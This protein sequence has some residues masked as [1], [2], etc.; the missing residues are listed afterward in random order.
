MKNLG[1]VAA[2]VAASAASPASAQTEPDKAVERVQQRIDRLDYIEPAGKMRSRSMVDEPLPPPWVL[3][4]GA[5]FAY[6]SNVAN[7]ETGRDQAFHF[8][9]SISLARDWSL[10]SNVTLSTEAGAELD[11]YTE[12]SENDLSDWYANARVTVGDS[13]ETISPYADYTTLALYEKRF[14]AHIVTLHGFTVGASRVWKSGDKGKWILD[15][16][17]SRREATIKTVELNRLSATGQY[18]FAP[19]DQSQWIFALA[20][21]YSDYSGGTAR[22]RDDKLMR[23]S[24]AW[25]RTF[26]KRV[27]L[28]L[29]AQF[30]RNWSDTA[31]KSYSVFDIGPSATLTTRF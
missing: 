18:R 21:Q 3:T 8:S 11:V 9:P 31:N 5:P 17:A 19:D 16:N 28:K 29:K 4:I 13:S 30:E 27:T 20:G 14:D 25:Q 12:F 26:K 24:V 2:V 6:N 1:I 15:V 22:A 7:A 23:L 10:G